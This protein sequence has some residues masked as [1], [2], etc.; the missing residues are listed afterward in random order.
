M[1]KK[2]GAKNLALARRFQMPNHLSRIPPVLRGSAVSAGPLYPF[3]LDLAVV[4]PSD[5]TKCLLWEGVELNQLAFLELLWFKVH[6]F[7]FSLIGLLDRLE[8]M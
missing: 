4:L 6:L 2:S 8:V 1:E 5:N 3:N 7:S